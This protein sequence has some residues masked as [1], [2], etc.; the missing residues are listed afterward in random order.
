LKEAGIAPEKISAILTSAARQNDSG[1]IRKLVS[2]LKKDAAISDFRAT[3]AVKNSDQIGLSDKVTDKNN[4]TSIESHQQI[5]K[6]LKE[7]EN[8]GMFHKYQSGR[9]GIL[10]DGIA[11]MDKSQSTA[12]SLAD[13]HGL[14]NVPKNM[15]TLQNKPLSASVMSQVG[16]EIAGFVQRGDRFFTLQL[17]PPELGMVNIEMDVK[18]N[19][20]KMSI[21]TET[22]SAKDLLQANYADLRRVLEGYGVKIESFD[23]QLSS[24]LNQSATNGDSPLNQQNHHS[25]RFGK[26]NFN[27][28]QTEEN[29]S[30][31]PPTPQQSRDGLVD[32]LA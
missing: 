31:P 2:D 1:E 20:L 3:A 30:E 5:D 18:E 28:G 10:Y 11:G 29:D 12:S 19:L 14:A 24:S 6:L 9:Q 26:K 7:I 22:G 13:L 8:G 21:V 15:G 4:H 32:L 25:G 17:K 23:I 16:K 27:T